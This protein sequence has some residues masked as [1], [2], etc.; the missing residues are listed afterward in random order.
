M[1]LSMTWD[2]LHEF[3]QCIRTA[4]GECR[5]SRVLWSSQCL[6]AV[7]LQPCLSSVKHASPVCYRRMHEELKSAGGSARLAS[8][9]ASCISKA[10]QLLA[11]KA[12]YMAATGV[13]LA[14]RCF[15]GGM[16]ERAVCRRGVCLRP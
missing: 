1:T 9:V 16:Q 7:R 2:L 14:C 6:E 13:A 3:T 5:H 11:E 12:E 8:Q 4:C 10:L 15:F